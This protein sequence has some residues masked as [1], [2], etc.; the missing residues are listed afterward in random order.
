M[1]AFNKPKGVKKLT[2]IF[3]TPKESNS[4][5]KTYE[6]QSRI[7]RIDGSFKKYKVPQRFPRNLTKLLKSVKHLTNIFDVPRDLRTSFKNF[8]KPRKTIS[9]ITRTFEKLE[10][11]T[12]EKIIKLSKNVKDFV[13]LFDKLKD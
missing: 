12:P 3:D 8:Q 9:E 6:R 10:R 5:S 11:K 4:S 13:K 2:S 7:S 1:K